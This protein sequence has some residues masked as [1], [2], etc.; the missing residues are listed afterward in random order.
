M[1]KLIIILTT[2][3]FWGCAKDTTAPNTN[4]ENCN[5][6]DA[7]GN[8]Y[9]VTDILINNVPNYANE[10]TNYQYTVNGCAIEGNAVSGG[11]FGCT[12]I[13]YYQTLGAL[14]C[15]EPTSGGILSTLTFSDITEDDISY[16]INSSANTCCVGEDSCPIVDT[17]TP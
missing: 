12:T 14:V 6:V 16:T 10:P 5:G 9:C 2:L 13:K 3:A 7:C 17:Y 8:Y 4:N 11:C 15:D 1:K